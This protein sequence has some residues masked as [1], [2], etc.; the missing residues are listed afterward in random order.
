[1]VKV[2]RCVK[3]LFLFLCVQR[4]REEDG[5][6]R[7]GDVLS[8]GR[9]RAGDRVGMRYARKVV[10]AAKVPTFHEHGSML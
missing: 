10:N 2:F 6:R 7:H 5:G 3:P 8:K 9:R 4:R 1:M